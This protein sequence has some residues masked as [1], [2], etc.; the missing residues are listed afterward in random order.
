LIS[1]LLNKLQQPAG[2]KQINLVLIFVLIAASVLRLYNLAGRSLSNDELSALNRLR[3]D[4]FGEMIEQGVKLGDFHPAGVQVFLWFWTAIFGNGVWIVRL[5]FAVSGIISV[6]LVYLIGKRW[7][8]TTTALFAA[9]AMAFLQYPLLYSQLARPYAPGLLFGL[10]TVWFWSA[11]VFNKEFSLKA[12]TGFVIFATLAAYTHHYSFLFVILVGLTGLPLI[13][14]QNLISYLFAGG[15]VGLL[16]LPHLGIFLHQFGIGGVG[17]DEGWLGK[18][19]PDWVFGYISYAFNQSFF[20]GAF[21]AG[22]VI[23]SLFTSKNGF[24]K[25]RLVTLFWPLLMPAVGYFYSLWRNPILQYSILIFSFPFLL[26][27][28]FSFLKPKPSKLVLLLIVAFLAVGVGSTVIGNRFYRKQHFGEFEDIA[29]K[30]ADWNRRFGKEN[31][32]NTVVANAPFYIHYYLDRMEPDIRFAQYDNRTGKD[33]FSLSQMVDSATTDWFAH[34]NTKPAPPEIPMIIQDKY[35]CLSF[36]KDYH[37]LSEIWLFG[38]TIS[39]ACI[40]P[41]KPVKSFSLN[42]DDGNLWGANPK[43]L[44]SAIFVSSPFSYLINEKTLYGPGLQLIIGK[45]I[46]KNIHKVEME[47]SAFSHDKLIEM[48][49]VFSIEN[50]EGETLFWRSMRLENFIVPGKWGKAFFSRQL[51]NNIQPGE[52]VKIYV[53]NL[54][55]KEV[56]VD[57]FKVR[58]YMAGGG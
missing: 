2:I 14:K 31:I 18:P 56:W 43:F 42:F 16:Y 33:L 7:F 52:V 10:A 5:P 3:F 44:D 28:L 23:S 11:L 22:V 21:V 17:G 46:Q 9:A 8:G 1:S 58:F 54:K 27:F 6:W 45:D 35:P 4:T 15:L 29:E 55:H 26:L 40:N 24:G 48:A 57:D 34:A 39:D 51:P 49:A 25:L 19:E 32:T 53:W 37:G 13:Q 50:I 20:I 30:F 47:M 41:S 36:H 12:A 38:K